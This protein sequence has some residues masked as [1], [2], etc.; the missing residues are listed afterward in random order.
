MAAGT[1]VAHVTVTDL[2]SGSQG[3]VECKLEG[4]DDVTASS[5]HLQRYQPDHD[6]FRQAY[7]HCVPKT[8]TFFE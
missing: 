5:F 1:L 6:H 4:D 8:S 3:H 2:D 7:I